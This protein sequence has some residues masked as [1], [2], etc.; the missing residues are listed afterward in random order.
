MQQPSQELADGNLDSTPAV[1]NSSGNASENLSVARCSS[2]GSECLSTTI[3]KRSA[4]TALHQLM[5]L[6]E[7]LLASLS[8][9]PGRCVALMMPGTFTQPLSASYANYDLVTSS[10]SKSQQSFPW[11]VDG[12]SVNTSGDWSRSGTILSGIAFQ[13]PP[14]VQTMSGTE[15]GLLPTQTATEIQD[16]SQVQILA[17][18]DKGGRVARRICTLR[19]GELEPSLVVRESPYFA[20]RLMGFPIGHTEL[21]PSETP[22]SRKSPTSSARQSTKSKGA[23]E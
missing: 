11:M 22:S 14:L 1:G 16:R 7:A 3:L 20:E 2:N 9:M 5:R 23:A 10:W 21:K 6:S 17:A 4:S 13:L 12:R 15:F 18:L 19:G 8:A